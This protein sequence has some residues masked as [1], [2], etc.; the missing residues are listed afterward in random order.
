MQSFL[1][2]ISIRLS[3]GLVVILAMV[4]LLTGLGWIAS[5]TV[6]S[7]FRSEVEHEQQAFLDHYAADIDTKLNISRASLEAVAR[8]VTQPL[9]EDADAA[10]SFLDVQVA[11]HAIFDNGLS[12]VADD[13]R[14]IAESPFLPSGRNRSISDREFFQTPTRTQQPYIS[15]PYASKHAA[16]RPAIVIVIPVF[17]EQGVMT[18]HLLG[19]FELL[20]SH[21]LGSLPEMVVGRKG[22][23]YLVDD[24]RTVIV[25]PDRSRIL[26][27]A[28]SQGVNQMLERGLEG[29]EGSGETIT[30]YGVRQLATTRWLKTVRW[31]LVSNYPMEELFQP[32]WQVRRRMVLA[33]VV[34]TAITLILLLLAMGRVT[35][36]LSSLTRHIEQMQGEEYPSFQPDAFGSIEVCKLSYSFGE[37]LQRLSDR[38]S[39]IRESEKPFRNI[40]QHSPMGMH[41]YELH[42]DDRLIFTAANPAADHLLK[43]D[44][45]QFIGKTIEEAF[46]PL[47][48]TEVPERYRL[49]ARKGESWQTEQITYHNEEIH[50]AFEVRAFQ[51]SPGRMVAVFMDITE[52][53]QSEDRIRTSERALRQ[54]KEELAALNQLSRAVT[55]S[56]SLEAV[57]QAAVEKVAEVLVLD[58][59]LL[60][61]LR[62]SELH[63]M[64]SGPQP[65]VLP[66]GTTPVHRLG[67]CLC[68][69]A[70][71][72]AQAIFCRNVKED[73]RCTLQ[74][75]KNAGIHSF[76]AIPLLFDDKVL[77]VLG[78]GSM[79]ESD[80]EKSARFLETAAV[81]LAISIHNARIYEQTCDYAAQLQQH[82]AERELT[83]HSIRQNERRLSLAIS[84]TTDAIW[85]WNL[86]THKT[87]FSPRWYEMLG[88]SNREFP[89]TFDTWQKLCHPDDYPPAMESIQTAMA[90]STRYVAEFRM[91]AKDGSWVWILGRGDVVEKDAD[92]RP[93]L[94]TGTNT[95]ITRHKHLEEQLRQAHKAEAIGQLAGGIAH[96]FNNILGG[97]LGFTEL[98]MGKIA[99]NPTKAESYMQRVLQ[100]G[101]R[102]KDLVGQILRFSRQD[103]P[104]I[105]HLNLA[106]VVLEVL[107]LMQAALPANIEIH[108]N[109]APDL[110]TV[111]ADASQLH[112]L[113]MNLCTNAFHAMRRSSGVLAISLD[114]CACSEPIICRN[115]NLPAGMYV[116]LKVGDTGHGIDPVNL[117]RI[118]DP[119]FTTKEKGEGTGL[120]LSVTL[121]I[122]DN[123]G[124]GI[125]VESAKNEGTIFSIYLPE[126]T[127]LVETKTPVHHE[128]STGTERILFVDDENL[129]IE[130]GRDILGGLGYLVT[131]ASGSL[132]ALDCFTRSPDHFDLVITDQ[133]MPKM[134]GLELVEQLKHVRPEI[135]VI[136]CTGF[137]EN[138]QTGD[139]LC[140]NI[141]KVLYKPY[142]LIDLATAIREVLRNG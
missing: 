78:L 108:S 61:I 40:I 43:V 125:Q 30:S 63:L 48:Q 67:E 135:P 95:D 90:A 129:F 139:P 45:R 122:I 31:L 115:R 96:D 119:Y 103:V 55:S 50:G 112:Q 34:G 51:T 29:F 44:N 120:G 16:D 38:E 2:R 128:V 33:G 110:P 36:P 12:L 117:E 6:E 35:K 133:T 106:E 124:G 20:S 101:N 126:F 11:L 114:R 86:I 123:H 89:M 14:I 18:G 17:D 93:L 72:S 22:Y 136:L 7:T 91:R 116:R 19:G 32:V 25:H 85:E 76:A 118:F 142:S 69:Q 8:Q 21:F 104:E 41:L 13:G 92:G 111:R 66:A 87:Y 62:D 83:Q 140:R 46:P 113:V 81:H 84:A 37:L 94:L 59:A 39:R 28:A 58:A 80:L 88:Y 23:M 9:Y 49:A 79:T 4:A 54:R 15:R 105:T 107:N 24:N 127:S 75:C 98:A 109:I 42:A 77:G 60:F 131:C 10:Q 70:A 138:I 137:S 5:L 26:G 130:M 71:Q 141:S 3:V 64:A 53:K 121:G 100:A 99:G 27:A 65:P 52:R 73:A 56:L 82:I 57:C 68:G 97:I 134:T 132:E 47:T 102:A 1:N 74:E